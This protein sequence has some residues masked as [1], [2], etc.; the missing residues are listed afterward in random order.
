VGLERGPLTLVSTTDE[1]LEKKSSGS[2]Q[3]NS[4]YGR[5]DPCGWPHGTLYPQ[6][7]ALT[8]LTRGGCSVSTVCSQTQ[9]TMFVF[10]YVYVQCEVWFIWQ[11]H[12]NGGVIQYSAIWKQ[13]SGYNCLLWI[14]IL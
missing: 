12:A 3:E 7:L 14:L 1:L 2:G 8:P 5:R 10:V 13:R 4:D 6:K 11:F 9:P